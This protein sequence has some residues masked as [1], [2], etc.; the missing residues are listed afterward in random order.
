MQRGI[1]Q[2]I[3]MYIITWQKSGMEIGELIH[4]WNYIEPDITILD[5]F[6]LH[7]CKLVTCNLFHCWEIALG[8]SEFWW[9]LAPIFTIICLFLVWMRTI[10][11]C[12]KSL[13]KWWSIKTVSINGIFGMRKNCKCVLG[14]TSLPQFILIER[15]TLYELVARAKEF[16]MDVFALSD[17]LVRGEIETKLG[18]CQVYLSG[19]S[20]RGRI[21]E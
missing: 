19:V 21:G 4:T 20:R 12:S 3:L 15:P 10:I 5:W 2:Y 17:A 1:F 9:K 14:V 11:E 18:H 16:R 6:Q 7:V 8:I 13:I